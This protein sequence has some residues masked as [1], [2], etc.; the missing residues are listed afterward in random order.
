MV[1]KNIQP[2]IRVLLV[3]D[4]NEDYL[5][6]E[7]HLSRVQQSN[8][9]LHWCGDLSSALTYLQNEAVDVV[10]VDYY[11]AGQTGVELIRPPSRSD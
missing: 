9:H 10:L 2:F 4:D 1:D 5:I 7:H 8:Y 6:T 3:D 11:L